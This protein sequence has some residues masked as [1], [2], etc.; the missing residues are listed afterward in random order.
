MVAFL[1][2][3]IYHSGP[4]AR[5][6][7]FFLLIQVHLNKTQ[8]K[9]HIGDVIH[10]NNWSAA[11]TRCSIVLQQVSDQD[12]F[13]RHAHISEEKNGKLRIQGLLMLSFFLN[14]LPWPQ[15]LLRQ[16]SFCPDHGYASQKAAG[17]G[18]FGHFWS[19]RLV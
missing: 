5:L 14:M 17:R 4:H 9:L 3:D 11:S 12:L 7:H 1:R 2:S 15:L 19:L 16:T 8:S 10:I 13:I 18:H 6:Q